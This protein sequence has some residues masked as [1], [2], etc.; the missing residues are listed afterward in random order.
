M[1]ICRECKTKYKER[2]EY[3]DCGNNT[4]DY[5]E[6]KQP[7]I[8]Q[9]KA[10]KS[11]TLEQKAELISWVFFV[12]CMILSVIVWAIPVKTSHTTK[13]QPK[14]Q[15][16]VDI[17]SIPDIN[18]IWNDTPLYTQRQTGQEQQVQRSPLDELRQDVPLTSAPINNQRI[19]KSEVQKKNNN[20][21]KKNIVSNSHQEFPV[22][23]KTIQTKPKTTSSISQ[24]KVEKPKVHQQIQKDVQKK[25]YNPNSA[26]MLD[27][28]NNLRAVLFRHFAVG[29]ISGSGECSV[30]FAVN[31]NGKLINRKFSKESSN[32]ALNDAV[33]Y[34][35][36]SVPQFDIP[37]TEYNGQTIRMNF[38][39]DNG[40]YE[41]SIY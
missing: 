37:P 3:C 39:I 8:F 36:M 1:Y 16:N 23:P 26:V 13:Q 25:T 15:Q 30:Q 29:S 34:M 20:V 27:Y 17:K 22:Q 38:K 41:I 12:I 31:E 33:Y 5:V 4:F 14:V 21:G 2:V 32:K 28:K 6:E 7:V 9:E 35:L 24:S 18:R 11:L 40:N 19:T 10:K